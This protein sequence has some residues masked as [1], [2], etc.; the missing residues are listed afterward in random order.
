LPRTVVP[1]DGEDPADG[2]RSFRAKVVE[3]FRTQHPRLL[4]VLARLSG[5]PD[6]AADLTQE[7]FVTLVRRGSMPDAP[8]AWVITVALNRLRNERAKVSRRVRLL[9]RV[10]DPT[11]GDAP[12]TVREAANARAKGRQV[13]TALE[14]L[15]E[16]DA[17]LLV[18]RSEG[19]SYKDIAAALEIHEASIGTLLARAR[20]AFV[21]AYEEPHA[22][23]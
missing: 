15:S 17:R 6:L 13:R 21:A 1:S 8:E 7:A 12:P 23:R 22:P 5:D 9:S 19:Y 2:E 20:R 4:R 11:P 18:L 14:R 10:A 16:R 3:F